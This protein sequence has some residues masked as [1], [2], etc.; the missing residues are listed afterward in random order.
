VVF[1]GLYTPL[2]GAPVIGAALSALA[3]SGIR[4]TMIGT[5]QDLAEARRA[6]AANPDVRW[7][8]WV[9]AAELPGT[10]AAHDV[11]LGIFGTGPKA[12]RVVPNKVFQGAAAGCAIVTSDTPPQ[13]RALGDA[14]VLVRPGDPDGLAAAL[15]RLAGDHAELGRLRERAGRLAREQFSP[16]RVVAPLLDRLP[17]VVGGHGDRREPTAAGAGR[18]TDGG[19]SR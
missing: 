10:V 2:Q 8:D 9:P 6:G 19:R 4:V 14:A 17:G 18:D 7:L 3:G 1:Y 15:L 12:L 16:A 5:G 11:C 13:R